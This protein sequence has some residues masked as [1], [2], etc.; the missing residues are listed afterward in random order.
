MID[1]VAFPDVEDAT[2]DGLLCA[3]GDLSVNTL[4]SAYSQGIFPWFNDDQPI[5]WWS[6]DPRLVLFPDE[7]KVS[8]SLRKVIQKNTFEIRC[9]TA[10]EQVIEGCAL[11]GATSTAQAIEDTWITDAMHEAYVELH[12]QN[13]AHS[14]EVWQDQKLVGGLYGIALGSTFFGESMFSRVS[15]ASKLA[16]VGLCEH[17]KTKNITIIDCQVASTHLFSMG[18]KEITR[19]EFMQYLAPIKLTSKGLHT[20]HLIKKEFAQDIENSLQKF[21][22]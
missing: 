15:N 22:K 4:V 12:K 21:T 17:L 2:N 19:S 13:Y 5:L 11:R 20:S 3:G 18:A 7:V 9:N 8:R 1:Y 14:I 16:L 6:P 10:F